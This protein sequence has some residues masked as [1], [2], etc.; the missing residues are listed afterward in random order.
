MSTFRLETSSTQSKQEDVPTS[1]DLHRLLDEA[2]FGKKV[3]K[4]ELKSYQASHGEST[5]STFLSDNF[6]AIANLSPGGEGRAI[7]SADLDVLDTLL[8]SREKYT[9]AVASK[10][11]IKEHFAELDRNPDGKI[12]RGELVRFR[13]NHPELAGA[14]D[15]VFHNFKTMST[16]SGTQGLSI[17]ARD[18]SA[19]DSSRLEEMLHKQYKDV[20][21][22]RRSWVV[23]KIS[24]AVLASLSTMGDGDADQKEQAARGAFAAG[25]AIGRGAGWL[26]NK[27]PVE[28]Y[29]LGTARGAIKQIFRSDLS[30][31]AKPHEKQ[32]DPASADWGV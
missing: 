27:G 23:G 2:R 11:F 19:L 21:I 13:D 16:A 28:N 7:E 14:V 3:T 12:G 31:A 6:R 24:G 26:F 15:K 30:G 4:E 17:D 1:G 18:L 22:A 29:Y 20:E 9:R 32:Q 5:A 8:E 25:E 10:A